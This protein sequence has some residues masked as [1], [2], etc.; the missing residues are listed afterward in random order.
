MTPNG[1]KAKTEAVLRKKGIPYFSGL[2][3]IESE[4]ETELRTPEEVG[5]RIACLFCVV[6]CA[7]Y[8]SDTVYK[9]YHENYLKKH[10]LWDHLTPK[11]MSFLSNPAPDRESINQF[12]W[13]SENLFLLMWAV[14]LFE[15]LPWPDRQTD[16]GQI[17]KVF[18]GLDKSPWRFIVDLELRDKSEILDASDLLYRLHWATVQAEVDRQPPPRGLEPG[19][20]YEWHYAINWITKYG[21]SDWDDVPT[22]T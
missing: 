14:R 17:V 1:R 18:P 11:E 10:Q 2:P 19:V 8:V 7:F 3:C 20:V 13:R 16:T 5:I 21:N 12:T 15:K 6:G 9:K 22:G 4:D